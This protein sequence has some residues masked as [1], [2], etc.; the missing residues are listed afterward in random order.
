MIGLI[1][2][3]CFDRLYFKSQSFQR[4]EVYWSYGSYIWWI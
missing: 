1:H 4:C 2:I 3:T